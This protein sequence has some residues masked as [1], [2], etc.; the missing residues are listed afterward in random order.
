MDIYSSERFHTSHENI[1]MNTAY[2]GSQS[3]QTIQFIILRSHIYSIARL[4]NR[5]Q[6]V[7]QNIG[8]NMNIPDFLF[9]ELK[10][11]PCSAQLKCGEQ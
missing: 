9:Q 8:E 11:Y 4:G 7:F 6:H 5:L 2:L 1:H 3:K 10:Y